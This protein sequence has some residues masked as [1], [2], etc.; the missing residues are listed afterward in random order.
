MTRTSN[1]RTGVAPVAAGLLLAALFATTPLGTQLDLWLNDRLSSAVA[2]AVDTGHALL[3]T[4]D[5]ESL[6]DLEPLTGAWPYGRDVWAHVIDFLR[7]AGA[8]RT[9]INVLFAEPRIGDEQLRLAIER[10]PRVLLAAVLT[11]ETLTRDD[12]SRA[13]IAGLGWRVP[14][15]S[16]ALAWA[17]VS[18]PRAG[19]MRPGGIAVAS[20]QPDADGIV[21]R[22][23]LLH[24]VNDTYLP[25]L[26]LAALVEP[27]PEV[28][29]Q[30]TIGGGVLHV[31]GRSIATGPGGDVELWLPHARAVPRTVSFARVARAALTTTPDLELVES[32]L[33]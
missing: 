8:T 15:V 5:D 16:P 21:R 28:R 23:S 2:P 20:V 17:D 9:V 4:I 12:A 1:W 26:S 31:G 10:T 6:G 24:R 11:P 30:S 27:L 7:D 19:L 13:A 14:P 29:W 32:V 33:R 18:S 22:V 3:V 25:P